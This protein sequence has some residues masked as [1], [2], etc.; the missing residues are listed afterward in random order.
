MRRTGLALLMAALVMSAGACNL[1][2][3]TP[4]PEPLPTGT[5]F[6]VGQPT[7]TIISP[8]EGAEFLVNRAILVSVVANDAIGVTRIQLFANGQIVKT[9]SSQTATGERTFNAILDY[10]PRAAGAV[11]LEVLA[12][13][14]A[15]T[16]APAVVNVQVRGEQQA[17]TATPNPGGGLPNIPNDGVCR[18]LTL[19]NLNLRTG[20]STGFAVITVLPGATL[21]PII[22][23]LGDNSWWEVNF[24]GR[25]GWVSSEFTSESGNCFNV[26][27]KPYIT[28][29]P[30]VTPAPTFTS[31]PPPSATPPPT[32]S[33]TPLPDLVVTSILGP[34]QVA[35]GVTETYSTTIS[36]TGQAA[37]SQFRVIM[38]FDSTVYE[39]GSVS[40]LRPGES[41]L[42]TQTLSLMTPG[43]YTI[44]VE[45]DPDGAVQEISK[46]NNQGFLTVTVLVP[47]S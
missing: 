1:T 40:S 44:R 38:E 19:V 41:I 33:T 6:E 10:T 39:L 35:A 11:R 29:T 25:F 8:Q 17:I 27:I 18:A 26:P 34:T 3:E 4:T 20:P 9:V 5:A 30:I 46:V 43:T 36:N 16:S 23:R 21:M 37:T 47:V 28:P 15:V 2:R 13:R 7:V 24:G 12:Y 32:A 14:N 31:G 45:A 42:L 22:G